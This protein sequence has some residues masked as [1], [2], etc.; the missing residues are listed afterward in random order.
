MST[1]RVS[2]SH[3]A[4]QNYK[5]LKF[6]C[7]MAP[8]PL[9]PR[10]S[11]SNAP[12]DES[13]FYH[14]SLCRRV[15]RQISGG[16]SLAPITPSPPSPSPYPTPSPGISV[17]SGVQCPLFG[18]QPPPDEAQAWFGHHQMEGFQCASSV[19]VTH[20]HIDVLG[21]WDREIRPTSGRVGNVNHVLFLFLCY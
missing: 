9:T 18:P 3:V 20:F 7:D 16:S 2:D 11:P 4:F 15:V 10:P 17:S 21:I 12:W 19:K 8:P 1:Q 13:T 14:I 5:S 6:T